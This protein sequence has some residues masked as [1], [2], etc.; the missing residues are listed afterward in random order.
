MNDQAHHL[1]HMHESNLNVEASEPKAADH[2]HHR[3]CMTQPT[4]STQLSQTRYT[5]TS[6]ATPAQQKAKPVIF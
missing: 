4:G 2:Q 3:P 1:K 5:K 6:Q